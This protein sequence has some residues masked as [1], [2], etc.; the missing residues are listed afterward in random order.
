MP[1]TGKMNSRAVI[2]Q[3]MTKA[4]MTAISARRTRRDRIF[5]SQLRDADLRVAAESSV[6]N[7][8]YLGASTVPL[9][10]RVLVN[11]QVGIGIKAV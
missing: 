7:E 6:M 10:P 5:G 2:A 11:P 3:N 1:T 9:C 8:P 4:T